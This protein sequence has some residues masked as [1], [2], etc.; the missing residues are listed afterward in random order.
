MLGLK[1]LGIGGLA[2]ALSLGWGFRVDHLRGGYKSQL[3]VIRIAFVDMGEK[4]K[5]DGS[6]LPAIVNKVGAERARYR[7]ERDA[8]RGLVTTQSNSIRTLE[9]ETAEAARESEANLRMIAEAT[10]QRDFWIKRARAAETRTE[11][12]TAQE[13]LNECEQV[14]DALYQA[15]F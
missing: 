11:R 8:A 6:D 4:P 5:K 3:D 12:R 1:A 10:R 13:E 14:L 15:G 9:K 2:L 7:Q